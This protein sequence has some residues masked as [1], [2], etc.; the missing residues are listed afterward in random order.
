ME[1]AAGERRC[2]LDSP[3]PPPI[4]K[5]LFHARRR[6]KIGCRS[7]GPLRDPAQPALALGPSM[8]WQSRKAW[9]TCAGDQRVLKG[10]A[11]EKKHGR[12]TTENIESATDA[13]RTSR[14]EHARDLKWCTRRIPTNR[15]DIRLGD[16]PSAL[17]L[18][19]VINE[20]GERLGRLA[21]REMVQRRKRLLRVA[22]GDFAGA[23]DGT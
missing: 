11:L 9:R 6:L 14:G 20:L 15:E 8:C 13:A 21:G 5:A 23:R 18:E 1:S 19:N 22:V 4:F 16:E 3:K 17:P 7:G 10:E 2:P 12:G